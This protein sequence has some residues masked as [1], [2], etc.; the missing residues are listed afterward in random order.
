LF[1]SRKHKPNAKIGRR[2]VNEDKLVELM[3]TKLLTL[4]TGK[5]IPINLTRIDFGTIPF[6]EQ[7]ALVRQTDIFL[8]MHGAGMTHTLWLHEE[9][10]V[11]EL[12]PKGW[13]QSTMRNISKWLGR[14]YLSWQN[15]HEKNVADHE[16]LWTHVEEDEFLEVMKAA[17][18]IV[19]GFHLG[20][21]VDHHHFDK[22]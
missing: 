16:H 20:S 8:G 9:S 14:A 15:V 5:Q 17:I 12:F 6:K 7:M 18:K 10:V 4:S 19:Q 21:G 13:H 1:S 2:I 3:E 11:V 22:K